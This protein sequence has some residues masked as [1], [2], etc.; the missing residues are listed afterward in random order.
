MRSSIG[1]LGGISVLFVG[2]YAL[3]EQASQVRDPAVTN[4][5][6]SSSSAFNSSSAVFEG[7]GQA[8]APGVVWMGVAA[9]ILIALGYLLAAGNS[10]R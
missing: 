8:F 10:G 7:V 4:G 6:N 1:I 3:S 2:F 9:I 5:T